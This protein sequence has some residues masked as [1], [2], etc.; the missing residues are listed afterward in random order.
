MPERAWASD[1]G[2]AGRLTDPAPDQA[3]HL[4]RVLRHEFIGDRGQP[5]EVIDVGDV[6]SEEGHELRGLDEPYSGAQPIRVRALGD[7]AMSFVLDVPRGET[8][9]LRIRTLGFS[10]RGGRV[11]MEASSDKRRFLFV[12]WAVVPF[13]PSSAMIAPLKTAEPFSSAIPL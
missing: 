10:R 9:W 6:A 12:W 5:L 13:V 2:E 3:T 11:S 1:A 8:V 4:P 7:E